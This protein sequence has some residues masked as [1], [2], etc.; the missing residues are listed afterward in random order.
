MFNKK[1]KVL[2]EL[3]LPNKKLLEYTAKCNMCK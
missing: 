2:T 1:F 3:S